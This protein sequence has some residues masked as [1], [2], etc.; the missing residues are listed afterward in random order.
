MILSY[1][2]VVLE[3]ITKKYEYYYVN[4]RDPAG[5]L[6]VTRWARR[7]NHQL[8]ELPQFLTIVGTHAPTAMIVSGYQPPLLQQC[9]ATVPDDISRSPL[10]IYE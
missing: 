7:A 5:Q 10:T 3:Y 9:A 6:S 4:C 1:T 2:M 8:L